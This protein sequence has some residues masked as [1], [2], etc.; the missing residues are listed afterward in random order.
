[1]RMI[2]PT[3]FDHLEEC[4]SYKDVQFKNICLPVKT[5]YPPAE[6]VNE[7]PAEQRGVGHQF[8]SPW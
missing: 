1:V 7:T 2:L 4:F 3:W 8:F 5:S 6:T